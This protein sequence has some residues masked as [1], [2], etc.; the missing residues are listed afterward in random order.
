MP[1]LKLT[2]NCLPL[3]AQLD[4]FMPRML[5]LN[6]Q[7]FA[8]NDQ[9][10]KEVKAS[11]VNGRSF[12]DEYEAWYERHPEVVEREREVS[13]LFDRAYELAGAIFAIPPRTIAGLAVW[14]RAL[15][16]DTH[17]TLWHQDDKDERLNERRIRALVE[18]LCALAG[19]PLPVS[20]AVLEARVADIKEELDQTKTAIAD[21]V[22][23]G[24]VS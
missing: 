23:R 11:A 20:V 6:W 9:M 5:D 16:A 10:R 2:P 14:A 12:D 7:G 15:V 3:G 24:G 17:P 13:S 1:N 21:I 18:Q 4:E 19:A 22:A 8:D